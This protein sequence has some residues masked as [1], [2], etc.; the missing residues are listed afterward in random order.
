MANL[1]TEI[2]ALEIFPRLPPTALLRFKSLNKFFYN[3][4][5]SQKFIDLHLHYSVSS[6]P[7]QLLKVFFTVKD[8]QQRLY[9]LDADSPPRYLSL[10]PPFCDPTRQLAFVNSFNGLLCLKSYGFQVKKM[11]YDWIILN[12]CTGQI[13]ANISSSYEWGPLTELCSGFG[14][15]RLNDDYKLVVVEYYGYSRKVRVYS[16]KANSWKCVENMN[17]RVH[18]LEMLIPVRWASS[19]LIDNNLLHWLVK[20]PAEIKLSIS[21]FNLENEQW[22]VNV[23]LP[24]FDVDHL[25][26]DSV[27]DWG[28]HDGCLCLSIDN[29]DTFDVWIMKEYRVQESWTRIPID[30]SNGL[31]RRLI[32]PNVKGIIEEILFSITSHLKETCNV[33]CYGWYNIR[34]KTCKIFELSGAPQ[35]FIPQSLCLRSLV[36]DFGDCQTKKCKATQV[37]RMKIDNEIK[38][39]PANLDQ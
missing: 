4:I 5:S 33:T 35:W 18:G 11:M 38:I 6:S 15:D 36:T 37:E 32:F 17:M 21:C 34:D 20:Y 26:F 10:P 28:V 30:V 14:Y 25:D 12:P 13:S 3:L 1:P 29:C 24:D 2:I 27:I 39:L 8:E 16:M 9:F 19:V 22:A 31:Y 23:T 7:D